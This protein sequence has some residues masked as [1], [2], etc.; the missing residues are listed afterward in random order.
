MLVKK[1]RFP[2]FVAL[3]QFIS[4]CKIGPN[5]IKELFIPGILMEEEKPLIPSIT[6]NSFNL[7]KFSYS[8]HQTTTMNG[9]KSVKYF[10]LHLRSI[11]SN[12]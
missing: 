12:I 4:C 10:P 9:K 2:Y 1:R 11:Y 3:L 5:S 6:F 8:F 7:G